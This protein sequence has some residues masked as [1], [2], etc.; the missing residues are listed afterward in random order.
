MQ[1]LATYLICDLK[2][3]YYYFTLYPATQ[4]TDKQSQ[5]KD[6]RM[7]GWIDGRYVYLH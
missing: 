4:S 6:G 5:K 3:V 1:L 7:D 2:V